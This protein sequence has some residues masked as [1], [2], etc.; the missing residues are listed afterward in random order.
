MELLSQ[1]K[2]ADLLGVSHTAIAKAIKAGYINQGWDQVSKKINVAVANDEWGNSIMEKAKNEKEKTDQS[3]SFD[4]SHLPQDANTA[5]T[6]TI[7][8]ADARRL[9]ETYNAEIARIEALR[10]QGLY[11]E[12]AAVYKQLFEFA[13]QIRVDMQ[14]IPNRIVDSILDTKDRFTIQQIISQ[15]INDVLGKLSKPPELR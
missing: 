8:I 6:G 9:K 2:Y 3:I 7:S 4:S 11:V 14:S 12:K 13:K 1:R 10:L 5:L 15:E